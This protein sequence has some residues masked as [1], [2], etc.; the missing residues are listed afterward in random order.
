M[1]DPGVMEGLTR[2]MTLNMWNVGGPLDERIR[3]ARLWVEMLEPDVVCFQELVVR[4]GDPATH[5]GI[6]D[7]LGYELVFCRMIPF[8]D[9]GDFGNGIVTRLPVIA[10][11]EVR[12]PGLD[13]EE[14]RH[15]Q[16]AAVTLP[17]GQTMHVFNTHLNWRLDEGYVRQRQVQAIQEFV[18]VTVG[19][20]PVGA[21][22]PVLC[23]D[24][25]ATPESAEIAYLAGFHTLDGRSVAWQ[26]AW[27][28]AGSGDGLTWDNRNPFATKDHEP[29][30][31]LDYIW[32]GLPDQTNGRGRVLHARLVCDVP[33]TG[34]YASDHLG[35]M[36]EITV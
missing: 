20:V 35:V 17:T 36:A 14:N 22:P 6:W 10:S 23:G 31:R 19:D 4:E 26:D 7:G 16:H 29:R 21:Q 8:G 1:V 24:F 9:A 18:D 33:L 13:R 32:V 30:R 5:W 12:L 15:V 11:A 2:V 27:R 3:E 28:A 25:N 34:T